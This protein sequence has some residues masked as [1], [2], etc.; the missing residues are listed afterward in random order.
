MVGIN[1]DIDFEEIH[2]FVYQHELN[3][4]FKITRQVVEQKSLLTF[5]G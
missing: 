2:I 1:P 3:Y 5:L 4:C